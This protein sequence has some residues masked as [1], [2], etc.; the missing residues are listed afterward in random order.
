[1]SYGMLARN[2]KNVPKKDVELKKKGKDGKLE[3]TGIGEIVEVEPDGELKAL[4]GK[5]VEEWREPVLPWC[6]KVP[7]RTKKVIFSESRS[8]TL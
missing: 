2:V 7:I 1:M 3:V 5:K 6:G 4:E 8:N